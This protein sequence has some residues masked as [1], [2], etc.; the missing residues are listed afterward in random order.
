ML[1]QG[2]WASRPSLASKCSP[3][4][5]QCSPLRWRTGELYALTPTSAPVS[6]TTMSLTGE[7]RAPPPTLRQRTP[8][9]RAFIHPSTKVTLR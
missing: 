2:C 4:V 6:C 9:R 1:A 5:V 3:R 8:R 7:L